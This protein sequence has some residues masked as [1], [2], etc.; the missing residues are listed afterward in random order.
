MAKVMFAPFSIG[1]GLVAGL[2]GRQLFAAIWGRIDDSEAPDPSHR[3]SPW[4]KVLLAAGLEGL[5]FALVRAA[6]DRG[7]RTAFM[8]L[9]G[10]WPGEQE[11]EPE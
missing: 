10:T 1:A 8:R 11:P 7:A 3:R 9:T 4:S 6:T 2:L 5:V